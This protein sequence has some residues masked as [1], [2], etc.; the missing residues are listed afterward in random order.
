MPDVKRL[1][2]RNIVDA[3]SDEHD[4]SPWVKNAHMLDGVA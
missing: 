4:F 2:H 1:E 3:I